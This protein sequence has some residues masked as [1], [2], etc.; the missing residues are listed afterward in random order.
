MESTLI[1]CIF[2]LHFSSL[3]ADSC[4]LN[5]F[6]LSLFRGNLLAQ[7]IPL[8]LTEYII[9]ETDYVPLKTFLQ[10]MNYIGSNLSQRKSY[11]LFKV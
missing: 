5:V 9:H 8:D 3:T 11:G 2:F 6:P 4:I 1:F 10:N 7:S